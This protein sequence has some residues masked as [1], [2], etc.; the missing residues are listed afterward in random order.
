MPPRPKKPSKRLPNR[1]AN[2]G[3]DRVNNAEEEVPDLTDN[4]PD[5]A[6]DMVEWMRELEIEEFA[7]VRSCLPCT[8][9]ST[10]QMLTLV[11]GRV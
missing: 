8:H 9:F 1:P 7:S 11:Y 5:L 6:D 4:A 3:N 2:E 10:M